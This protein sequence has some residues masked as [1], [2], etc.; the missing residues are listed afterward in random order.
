MQ[1]EALPNHVYAFTIYLFD[2]YGNISK[3]AHFVVET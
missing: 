2:V 1:V 3:P